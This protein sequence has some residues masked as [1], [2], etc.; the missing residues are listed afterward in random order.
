MCVHM[1]VGEYVLA[2]VCARERVRLC[3]CVYMCVCEYERDY[4][5]VNVC[6]RGVY[7]CEGVSLC[8]SMCSCQNALA[9]VS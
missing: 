8:I 2:Y 6:A 1:S 4:A 7:V 3:I 9:C 5:V